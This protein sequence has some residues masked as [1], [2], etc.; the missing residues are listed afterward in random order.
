MSAHV[1]KETAVVVVV[2][3][4]VV[5]L[6]AN[7]LITI[8][9]M[10]LVILPF[11]SFLFIGIC[12]TS[13]FPAVVSRA[14]LASLLETKYINITGKRCNMDNIHTKKETVLLKN[15]ET[16]QLYTI[17]VT[18]EEAKRLETGKFT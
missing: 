18:P 2:V 17:L 8:T 4:E 15:E 6:M 12:F 10:L 16:N 9:P 14:Q 1:L 3:V 11:G 7:L 5:C 13:V